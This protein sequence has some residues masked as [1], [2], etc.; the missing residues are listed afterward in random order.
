MREQ[1]KGNFHGMGLGKMSTRGHVH[2]HTHTYIHTHKHT[3]K[4]THTQMPAWHIAVAT[5]C[6]GK[7]STDQCELA[8]LHI[9]TNTHLGDRSLQL[10]QKHHLSH[11]VQS[12]LIW[13]SAAAH[14]HS[15]TPTH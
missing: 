13:F 15:Y 6:Q 5:R 3:H 11:S 14:T 8:L 10:S 4:H 7:A 2:T 1:V 9:N 12:Y